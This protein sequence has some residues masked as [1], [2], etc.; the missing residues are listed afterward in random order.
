V[1]AYVPAACSIDGSGYAEYY[2]L[3]DYEPPGAPNK[4]HPLSDIGAE[5]T[6]VDQAA[7][8]LL[9]V[10]DESDRTWM[11][12][13][14]V[15]ASGD[16]HV[17]LLPSL[18]SCA[19]T[20]PPRWDAR[21]GSQLASIGPGAGG[22]VLVV[23]GMSGTSTSPTYVA[24]LDTGAV[25]RVPPSTDL[26]TP[27]V[28]GAS[29]TPFGD[30]ALVAGGVGED[31]AT[32]DTAE[33]FDSQIGGFD[34]QQP[35]VLLSEAR[36]DHGAAALATGETLLVGGV[37]ADGT[38]PLSSMEIVDPAT[39]TVRVEGVA[40][41]AV[42]RRAPTVLRLASG[43]ILVAG[44]F[45]A[46]GPVTRLEW[47]APDVSA[48]SP[49]SAE[50]VAGSARS[51]IALDGGGALAVVAPPAGA[52]PGFGNVWV[53]DADCAVE[54]AAPIGGALTQP[55]L[56]GGAGGAPVLWT[57]DRWLQWSPWS[58]A[59]VALA[60]L[61]DTPARVGGATTSPDPGLAL[62]LDAATS[63]VTGLRFDSRG[64]YSPLPSPILASDARETAPDRLASSGVVTFD[65]ALGGLVL[66]PGASAFVTDR[67][68]AD[69]SIDVAAPTGE[70]AIIVLRDEIGAELE[71]GG[72]SCPTA[73]APNAPSAHVERRAGSVTWSLGGGHSGTC[74]T[75]VTPAARLSVGLRG[76]GASA[77]SVAS[78]LRIQRLGSP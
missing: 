76:A 13:A 10:A 64:P 8:E 28:R 74:R 53:I 43:Q 50:L 14:S 77:R 62:W 49:C 4:G 63:A 22:R 29:V 34:Q 60:V 37:G 70:P 78:D 19:L 30:G 15:A 35:P 31:N 51:F 12:R 72:S 24:R 21:S 3:G 9:V 26:R 18:S 41:L 68:Y 54:A 1:T 11:G 17:L 20:T 2:A 46:G 40:R 52:P 45:D 66:A 59:F 42:A 67:T 57:G 6:E 48:T 55:V 47:F 58:G 39:R 75:G 71:I 32:L 5:L 27:R 38:T 73:T 33:V 7:R 56:F 44:G 23:G 65:S 61:D 25:S 16:V 36:S 69:V